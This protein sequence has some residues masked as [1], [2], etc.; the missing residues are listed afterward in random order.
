MSQDKSIAR[1]KIVIFG[2][3]AMTL[4]AVWLTD[5]RQKNS[6]KPKLQSQINSELDESGLPPSKSLTVS[7]RLSYGEKLLFVADD[8]PQ[9]QL[10]IK[11]YRQGQYEQAINNFQDYLDNNPNDPEA[12]IYLNNSYASLKGN[13]TNIGVIV[14]IGGSLDVAK[15]ILRGVAQAQNEINLK[16]GVQSNET[17]SSLI[18]VQIANDDNSPATAKKI[19]AHLV[20]DDEIM[21]V[22]GHNSSSASLAAAPVYQAGRL[23][24]IS[25]TSVARELSQA[26]SYIF[27]TTPSS[28]VLAET[29][30]Q[31]TAEV[32]NRQR[33]AVC[34][35]SNSSASSS[36]E[37]EFSLTLSE[38][39]GE[40][41]PIECDFSSDSFNPDEVPSKAVANGAEALLLIP[42]VN[43][44]NQAV[45]VTK[46][47]SNR[48]PLL[49]NHSMYT[50]ET[51]KVGQKDVNG[52]ILPVPWNS[53][54]TESTYIQDAKKLWGMQGNWR[55]A[56]AYD[57]TK[58]VLKGLEIANSREELQQVLSNNGFATQGATRKV[59]F[60]PSGD[61]QGEATIVKVKSGKTSGTGYDF[62]SLK[63]NS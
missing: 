23:V 44:I 27:R 8:N 24:M 13:S 1:K 47:N 52:L 53:S 29:I 15:E 4:T 33:V 11:N 51:L 14:P 18:K 12:L 60:T 30:A 58:A 6:I 26:G 48:L 7:Q 35:D 17:S 42:A 59:V 63:S 41:V 16:G 25:P 46:A 54:N 9:K 31:Y 32:A 10:G 50:Y 43:N 19:A 20:A 61:R 21:G 62:V 38:L 45:E 55:T 2:V 34:Y 49:G 40:I 57:A 56:M 22:I 28:R 36:F 3:L 39:G 5:Q 37:E